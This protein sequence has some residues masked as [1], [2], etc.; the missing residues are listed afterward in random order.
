MKERKFVTSNPLL[1][2]FCVPVHMAHLYEY[3]ADRQILRRYLFFLV[4]NEYNEMH[5]FNYK[6]HLP[7]SSLLRHPCTRFGMGTE[8]VWPVSRAVP[9]KPFYFTVYDRNNIRYGGH[10]YEFFTGV[11][12]RLGVILCS[13]RLWVHVGP[14]TE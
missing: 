3:Y 9:S 2:G 6:T 11:F 4:Y 10:S 1:S 8:Q 13:D 5:P 12:R 7:W 14:G